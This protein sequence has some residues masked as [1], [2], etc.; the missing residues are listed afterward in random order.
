MAPEGEVDK[1]LET[2]VANLE[3]TNDLDIQPPVRCR[4]LL[5]TPLE[6]FTIGHTIVISRGLIDVLPDEAGLA[7]VLA[8]ELGHILSGHELDTKY[9][10]TD[11]ILVADKQPL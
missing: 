1:V 7:M 6:S 11:Q 3:I 8:H 10:F 9:A 4:V 5:T 2:V